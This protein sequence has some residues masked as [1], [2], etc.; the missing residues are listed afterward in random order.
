MVLARVMLICWA[1]L[2]L[3]VRTRTDK[4]RLVP[5][6]Y[7]FCGWMCLH[8]CVSHEKK[9]AQI[10]ESLARKWNTL[11][12]NGLTTVTIWPTQRESITHN[13]NFFWWSPSVRVIQVPLKH[14]VRFSVNPAISHNQERGSTS[15]I[16]VGIEVYYHEPFGR[17]FAQPALF[18][19]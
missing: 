18:F 9:K 15:I 2:V 16:I 10:L 14:W 4:L 8:S 12:R 11:E 7:L 5:S 3:L 6:N 17:Y 13:S 1:Y 19:Q